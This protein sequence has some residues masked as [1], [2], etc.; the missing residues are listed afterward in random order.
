MNKVVDDIE[1]ALADVADGACIAIGGFFS[2]G[3]PR[4]LLRGIVSKGIRHIT[5][6]CGAGPLV[7]A[8]DIA[9]KLIEG[10]QLKKIVDSYPLARSAS[11]GKLDPLELKIRSAEIEVEI[12]PMGTLIEKY[13]AAGAGLPAF[14]TPTGV[15]TLVEK[16]DAAEP[17]AWRPK[18]IR[19]FNGQCCI[20]EEALKPDVA[21]VHAFAG[22]REGNLQYRKT[23]RN[24][25]HVMAM[26]A[27]LTIAEVE[28]VVAPEEMEPDMVHTPG[29]YVN[30]ILRVARSDHAVTAA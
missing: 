14:Y 2:A 9:R 29:I 5:L 23:A 3:I 10:G 21:L 7:G 6:L 26:A 4:V 19:V 8:K 15:G 25:N 22:D 11:Q 24:F 1:S 18:E 12:I 30:R 28:H 16:G 13:R 27:G 20:L 17:G